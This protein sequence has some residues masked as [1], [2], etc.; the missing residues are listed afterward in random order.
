MSTR[1]PRVVKDF[2]KLDKE[3]REQIKLVYTEG[4]ADHLV[5]YTN[6]DGN[7]VT[8]L[9]FETDEKHYLVRMTVSQAEAIVEEDDDYDVDGNLTDKAKE[10]YEGKYA[11]LDYLAEKIPDTEDDD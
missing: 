5:Y 2:E 1:K 6:K 8:A 10:K 11:D 7:Q 9:P 3:I 4:F